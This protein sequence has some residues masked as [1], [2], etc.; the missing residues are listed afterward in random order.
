MLLLE[1]LMFKAA[2]LGNRVPHS[3]IGTQS[4]PPHQRFYAKTDGLFK[5]TDARALCTSR[6]TP[7]TFEL[8]TVEGLV[9]RHSKQQQQELPRLQSGPPAHHEEPERHRAYS[10][11]RRKKPHPQTI[12]W[13]YTG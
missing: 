12:R 5:L 13:N 4:P 9:V 8:K 7:I 10:D 2:F 3:S 11:H 1:R 6:R